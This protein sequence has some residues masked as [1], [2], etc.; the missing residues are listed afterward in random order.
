MMTPARL[1]FL[2]ME[3]G[4]ATVQTEIQPLEEEVLVMLMEVMD[5][6]EEPEPEEQEV[7]EKI[8]LWD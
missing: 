8:I 2:L 1:S 7:L 3:E 6:A 5:I 4:A